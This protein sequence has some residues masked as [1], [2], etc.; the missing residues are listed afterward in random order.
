MTDRHA[1]RDIPTK[2]LQSLFSAVLFDILSK[3]SSKVVIPEKPAISSA[4]VKHGPLH[5]PLDRAA[6][7]IVIAQA[8][9]ARSSHITPHLRSS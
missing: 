5:Q 7:R 3:P 1:L 8:A 6:N 4:T 9:N 2:R